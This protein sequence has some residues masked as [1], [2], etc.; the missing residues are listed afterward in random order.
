MHCC[1]RLKIKCTTFV[2]RRNNKDNEA[3][4]KI[5]CDRDKAVCISSIGIVFPNKETTSVGLI[6]SLANAILVQNIPAAKI[7]NG[8]K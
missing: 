3:K 1:I 4:V 6:G 7:K 5:L 2:V 8:E